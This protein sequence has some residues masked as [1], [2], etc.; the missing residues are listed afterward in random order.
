MDIKTRPKYTLQETHFRSRYTYRLKVMRWKKA[1]CANGNQKRAGV[2]ILI[3]DNIDF[4]IKTVTRDK[5]TLHNDQRV[6]SR[7]RYNNCKY[8]GTQH[9]NTSI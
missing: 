4:K 8:I 6:N 1:F 3:S 5:K 9:R 2:A 7:R